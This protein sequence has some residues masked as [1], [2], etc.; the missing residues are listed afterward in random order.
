VIVVDAT[1]AVYARIGKRVRAIREKR[2]MTQKALAT[3]VHLTRTSITNIE[4]GNQKLL[5]HTLVDIA[6]ALNVLPG[7][8]LASK[9]AEVGNAAEFEELIK[10]MPRIERDWIKATIDTSET[11]G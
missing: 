11:G 5:V 2:G 9:D 7:A 3:L 4:R 10:D 8:L 6:K 1:S